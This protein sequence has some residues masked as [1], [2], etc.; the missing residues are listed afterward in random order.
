MS[1][2]N[3]WTHA[4]LSKELKGR[5]DAE[6]VVDNLHVARPADMRAILSALDAGHTDVV[7]RYAD[8]FRKAVEESEK[9]VANM[10]AKMGEARAPKSAQEQRDDSAAA[11]QEEAAQAVQAA[12]AASSEKR[13]AAKAKAEAKRAKESEAQREAREA[14]EAEGLAMI[15]RMRAGIQFGGAKDEP[16]KP[17]RT[18]QELV[19][20]M[21][22]VYE[23][24]KP[25][26]KTYLVTKGG[27][28]AVSGSNIHQMPEGSIVDDRNYDITAL[29][30]GGCELED[31]TGRVVVKPDALG[32]SLL[33][34]IM[35]DAE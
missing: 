11:K 16:K 8:Q 28:Y 34:E 18:A 7:R 13:E 24:T 15:E 2:Y 31:V 9:T 14:A 30:Q 23:D 1:K 5:P 22:L 19:E 17:P 3:R 29:R 20:S 10:R 21:G 4:K 6:S 25:E 26:Q 35:E 33:V 32:N 27:Q 12:V